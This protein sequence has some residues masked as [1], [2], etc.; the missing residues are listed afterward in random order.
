MPSLYYGIIRDETPLDENTGRR[1][2]DKVYHDKPAAEMPAGSPDPQEVVTDSDP[3]LGFVN[4]QLAPDWHQP[5]KYTP[6]WI[7]DVDR[8][9]EHNAIIDRQVSTSGTAAQREASGQYGHGTAAHAIGIEP[10]FDLGDEAHK[11]G[12]EYFDASKPPA[13]HTMGSVMSVPP[14][15]DAGQRGAVMGEGKENAATA[16]QSST[17]EDIYQLYYT[18]VAG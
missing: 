18:Q 3:N 17:I 16:K 9:D 12:N 6:F 15:Y 14:G 5:E 8:Q 10:V 1:T 11:M 2:T 13:Q 4:R 7:P